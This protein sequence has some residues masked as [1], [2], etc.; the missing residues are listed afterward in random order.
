MLCVKGDYSRATLTL[1]MVLEWRIQHGAVTDPTTVKTLAWLIKTKAR[2]GEIAGVELLHDRFL[3]IARAP[4]NDDRGTTAV[5]DRLSEALRTAAEPGIARDLW[6][7][8]LEM[9]VQ[10]FGPKH[11]ETQAVTSQ[12]ASAYVECGEYL[13]AQTLLQT[14][15]NSAMLRHGRE[16]KDTITCEYNLARVMY[17]RGDPTKALPLQEKVLES[18]TGCSAQS[19]K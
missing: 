12:L 3:D 4:K 1:D 2:S 10:H 5:I 11:A 17:L 14:L 7:R 13:E 16:H 9:Y 15:L 6:K 19:T 18:A 8:A